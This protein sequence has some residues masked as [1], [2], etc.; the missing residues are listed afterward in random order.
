MEK[1]GEEKMARILKAR[2]LSTSLYS[3]TGYCADR[4]HY[5]DD[6]TLNV[7]AARFASGIDALSA[8]NRGCLRCWRYRA[9]DAVSQA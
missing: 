4:M 5:G 9:D 6:T 1:F 3:K 7:A 2:I 8:K